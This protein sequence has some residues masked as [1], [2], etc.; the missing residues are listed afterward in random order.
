MA[1]I[2]QYS[3]GRESPGQDD[4]AVGAEPPP[5]SGAGRHD[6]TAADYE[7]LGGDEVSW[8]AE[9]LLVP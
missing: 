8:G 7:D 9:R 5:S 2:G 4:S 3:S 6:Q 1:T